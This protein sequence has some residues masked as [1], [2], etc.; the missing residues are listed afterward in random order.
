MC[1]ICGFLVEG[2][3]S[4]HETALDAAVR[5]MADTLVHR[6]PDAAGSWVDAARG[7]AFGHRRLSIL[8]RS[9]EGAQPMVSACGRYVLV[10]NGEIYN[11]RE[12]RAELEAHG[13]EFRGHSDTEV[14]VEAISRW[15]AEAAPSRCD[16]MFALA[17]W[18]RREAT[19]TLARD[20]LGK[21]PLYYGRCGGLF[22]FASELKALRAHPAFRPSS[23]ASSTS[24]GNCTR[25]S[26]RG[27]RKPSRRHSMAWR[28]RSSAF[29]RFLR[30]KS[31]SSRPEQSPGDPCEAPANAL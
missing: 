2:G 20:R 30:P 25:P 8:D 6:G 13:H 17:V 24:S 3:G 11:F 9:P 5:R 18:D 29:W 10:Y 14:L 7:V 22:F 23:R 21:K 19:L 16:G 26:S 4:E 31:S 1:G 28:P 27:Y 15:G 12:L